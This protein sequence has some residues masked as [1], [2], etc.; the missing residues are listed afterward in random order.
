MAASQYITQKSPVRV[1]HLIDGLGGGGSERWIWDIVRLSPSQSV[2]HH[3]VTYFPDNGGFV[4]ARLLREIGVYQQPIQQGGVTWLEWMIECCAKYAWLVPLRK[5]LSAGLRVLIATQFYWHLTRAIGRFAPGIIH[6][7]TFRCFRVGV[8]LRRLFGYP[9]L[10]TVPALFSQMRD[11]G[12][13]SLPHDYSRYHEWVSRFVTGASFD[14]LVKVG[15]PSSK[16]MKITG[17][18]DI[19]QIGEVRNRREE[20]RRG[21]RTELSL[22]EDA[23]IA[24]S[25]GR[26]HISK[27]HELALEAM[28]TIMSEFKLVHWVVLGEGALRGLLENR[29][30]QLGY[31]SRMHLIGFQEDPLPYYAA[32]DIYLRTPVFEA[33]NLSSYQAMGMGLPVVGFDTGCETELIRICGHGLLVPCKDVEAFAGG[34]RA[35]LSLADRGK[36]WGR[37]GTEYCQMHLDIR[38]TIT[39]LAALYS[40]V[41]VQSF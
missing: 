2:C 35:I 11:A 14:E 41:A 28:S 33:E 3:V 34:I 40:Q 21:V 1:L 25:V 20:F 16:V 4:Y 24:L 38:Q 32:A 26:L 12:F 27:G 37:R 7:H 6:V 13:T 19:E 9:L 23:I 29:R 8:W 15:I 17:V 30:K 31:T 5:L 18:V 39:E 36:E 22:P 10:H